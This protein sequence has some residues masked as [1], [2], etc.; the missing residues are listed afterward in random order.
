MKKR[1]LY[2]LFGVCFAL[3]LAFSFTVMSFASESGEEAIH[4]GE[5]LVLAELDSV[6][7][8]D[9]SSE[10]AMNGRSAS[11]PR[12]A[13]GQESNKMDGWNFV[14]FNSHDVTVTVVAI[15]SITVIIGFA[16]ALFKTIHEIFSD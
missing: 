4:S 13:A 10:S 6:A 11:V 3:I 15:L 8:I 5:A 1:L 7:V 14:E 12:G 9:N 2:S 16:V